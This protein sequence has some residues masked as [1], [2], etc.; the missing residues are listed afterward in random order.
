MCSS[1]LE[2]LRE[3]QI[4]ET[5]LL[6]VL[7]ENCF[8]DGIQ[9]TVRVMPV[10]VMAVVVVVGFRGFVMG[11]VSGSVREGQQFSLAFSIAS[12]VNHSGVLLTN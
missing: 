3:E 10:F 12:D 1:D 11:S 6:R 4:A 5:R 8:D 7:L 2:L 9:E